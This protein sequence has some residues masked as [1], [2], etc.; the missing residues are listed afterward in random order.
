VLD[1]TMSRR[2]FV[3]TSLAALGSLTAGPLSGASAVSNDAETDAR[4][5]FSEYVGLAAALGIPL[6]TDEPYSWA[7]D[8]RSRIPAEAAAR[9]SRAVSALTDA[10]K[11]L[12]LRVEDIYGSARALNAALRTSAQLRESV[13][14]GLAAVVD[15]NAFVDTAA[16]AT[17]RFPE[18]SGQPLPRLEPYPL[19]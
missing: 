18:S 11:R 14:F 8:A 13:Q 16:L 10:H 5:A 12:S 19:G 15:P 4:A 9:S 7:Q 17:G 6:V 2:V 3:G 1:K